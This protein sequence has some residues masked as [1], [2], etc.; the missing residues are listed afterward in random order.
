MST[1]TSGLL[2]VRQKKGSS[3]STKRSMSVGIRSTNY[4][5]LNILSLSLA[6]TSKV[7]P[8]LRLKIGSR[9]SNTEV[10]L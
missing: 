10:T 7:Q 2:L 8:V 5:T 4:Q 6:K 3:S 9:V 1:A